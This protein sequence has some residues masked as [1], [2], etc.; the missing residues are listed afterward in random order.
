MFDWIPIDQYTSI[1]YYVLLVVM[2]LMLGSNINDKKNNKYLQVIGIYALFFVIFYMGLRP[3]NREF[4]D[5]RIYANIFNSYKEGYPITSL[6]DPLFHY[7]MQYSSKLVGVNIFFL[8]CAILYV[9][10]LYL[11]CKKWFASRWFFAFFML[12]VSFSFWAYGTNGIRN[13]IA[14]SFFL[15]GISREKRLFKLLWL[16][17]SVSFHISMLLPTVAFILVK[18]YNKPKTYFLFWL[19][20]IPL[21]L[22]AGGFW[23]NFFASLG[24]EDDRISYLTTEADQETFADTGFRWDFLLYSATGVFAGWYFI[25]KKKFD[26]PVYYKLFNIYLFTNAFWVLVIRAN[27]S[28]RFAYLSWFML[29]LVICYPL[30]NEQL[31]RSQQK[32]MGLIIIAYFGFTFLMNVI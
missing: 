28:N 15:Y 6:K 18:F 4:G 1:Y 9:V 31:I 10:P 13:G 25:F 30:I 24:F 21:S 2:F 20:C 7:F 19:L 23:E 22:A 17:M 16:L 11:V 32:K 14:S 12:V 26:D 29:A 3:I 27:F 8:V 5:M